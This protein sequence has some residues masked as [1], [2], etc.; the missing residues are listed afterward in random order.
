MKIW[1]E[2]QLYFM[3]FTISSLVRRKV[4]NA[5][6]ILCYALIVFLITSVL[7]FSGSLRHEAVAVLEGSPEILVQ[8]VV[9]GRYAPIPMAYASKI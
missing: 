7:F 1:L 5:A 3:D 4:K 9:A 8:R 2:R 6:L